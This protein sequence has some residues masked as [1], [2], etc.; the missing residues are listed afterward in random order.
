MKKTKQKKQVN[1]WKI[2]TIILF[3]LVFV[4]VI[5]YL[6]IESVKQENAKELVDLG[7]F[8]VEK[9][10]LLQMREVAIENGWS[11]ITITEVETGNQVV[12]QVVE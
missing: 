4:L 1:G 5:A 7:P 3:V 9:G 6:K 10:F 2:A 8:Q 11:N 12:L